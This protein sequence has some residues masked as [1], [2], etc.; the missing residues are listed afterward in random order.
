MSIAIDALA[1]RRRLGRDSWGIPEPF[2]PMGWTIDSTDDEAPARVIVTSSNYDP[3]ID[4]RHDW[5][6]HASISRPEMP[7]YADLVMLHKAV[8]PTGFAYQ[9]FVP[10]DEH[11]N[12][13]PRALHL[14]GLA[15]GESVLP[16]FG[17]IGTI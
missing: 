13:H 10:P 15:T 6:W 11:I 5:W 4:P 3:E 2:G 7:T 14:W 8:W 16:N 9:V 17:A 1:V 12:I